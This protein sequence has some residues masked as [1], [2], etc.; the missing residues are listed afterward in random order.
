MSASGTATRTVVFGYDGTL[1]SLE[2]LRW[3]LDHAWPRQ[4]TVVVSTVGQEESL[5]ALPRRPGAEQ[6]ARAM[7]EA[8]WMED[9]QALDAE[10]E[11]LV[12]RD[13][14]VDGLV[15]LARERDADLIVVG[16]QHRHGVDGVLHVSVARHLIDHAPCPVLVVPSPTPEART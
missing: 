6:R 5:L 9:E 1:G 7:L 12:E 13:A 8:L 2:A 11:M 16:H 3:L 15:R 10:V 4:R 14:P